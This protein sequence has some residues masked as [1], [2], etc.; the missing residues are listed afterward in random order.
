MKNNFAALV[1][2]GAISYNKE[3]N[4]AQAAKLTLGLYEELSSKVE[5]HKKSK[6]KSKDW[7]DMLESPNVFGAGSYSSETPAGYS[8]SVDEVLD[9]QEKEVIHKKEKEAKEAQEKADREKRLAQEKAQ[10]EAQAKKEKE[11][12]ERQEKEAAAKKAREEAEK[13]DKAL[14]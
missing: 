6:M 13:K 1:L 3:E 2:I 4:S 11:E 14:M 7:D 12:K 9:E 10:K 8:N 5:Q